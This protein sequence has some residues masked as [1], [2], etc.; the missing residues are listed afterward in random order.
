MRLRNWWMSNIFLL[1]NSSRKV[2]MIRLHSPRKW[3]SRETSHLSK[4]MSESI[5]RRK[6]SSLSRSS[7]SPQ[8]ERKWRGRHL[9]LWHKLVRPRKSSRSKSFWSS[10]WQRSSKR[11]N[12]SLILSLPCMKM[13]RM[14]ET[15]MSVRF[16]ILLRIWQRWRRESR[17][18][19]MRSKSSDM[20]Q[21][22]RIACSQNAKRMFKLKH[23]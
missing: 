5:L 2:S 15:S 13:S 12:S 16:K 23:N 20:S 18:Y 9:R 6:T 19:R 8:L 17:S 21:V 14:I 4:Q 1:V 11:L 10:T 7:S 22:R 3:S